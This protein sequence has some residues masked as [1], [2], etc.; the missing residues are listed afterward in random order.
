MIDCTTYTDITHYLNRHG[1]T[2][3]EGYSQQVKQQVIDL[4]E[5]TNKPNLQVMEIGFNAGHSAEVFL[6]IYLFLIISSSF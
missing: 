2:W 1:F 3:F 5:L 4:I 6:I